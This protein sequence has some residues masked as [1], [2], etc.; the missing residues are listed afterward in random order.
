M[1]HILSTHNRHTYLS[2]P[3]D[4]CFPTHTYMTSYTCQ[5]MSG[6]LDCY[7]GASCGRSPTSYTRLIFWVCRFRHEHA[8]APRGVMSVEIF[9]T[10]PPAHVAAPVPRNQCPHVL[11]PPPSRYCSPLLR[12][13]CGTLRLTPPLASLL[14]ACT[15]GGVAGRGPGH[16]TEFSLLLALSIISVL[17]WA[18]AVRK[19]KRCSRVVGT[20]F[21]RRHALDL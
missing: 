8:A 4:V 20:C 13:G 5:R 17:L 19:E 10:R 16:S 3:S 9:G 6:D 15:G 11:T 21:G 12:G 1:S 2:F 18:A 14:P 7:V